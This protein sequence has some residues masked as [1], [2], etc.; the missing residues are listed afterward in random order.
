MALGIRGSNPIWSEVDLQGKLFDGSFY[1]YVLTNTIPYIPARVFHDPDMAIP[2]TQ[3]IQFN[4]NGTLPIDIFYPPNTVFRLEFRKNNGIDPP[5]QNDAL[6]YE[7]NDYVPGEGGSTPIDTVALA[8]SNQ[9]TN[10][11]FALVNFISPLILIG[12]TNPDPINIGPGWSLE[13]AG[14]GN[15]TVTQV[16]L[17]NLNPNPSNAPYAL[18]LTLSGW[19]DNSVKLKQRFQVNGMLWANK[20]VSSTVTAR[21]DGLPQNIQAI[22][23]DS[24]G[25]TL[26]NVMD[27]EPVNGNYTELTGHSDVLPASTNPD[28]PPVAWIEYQLLLPSNVDIYLT[29]IQLVVQEVEFEPPFEQDSI[30]RQ[31]DHT[32][33]DAFPIVPI[34]GVIDF[35][36][37][38]TPLNYLG[39]NGVEIS[40]FT[41]AMLFSALTNFETVTLT[42]GA[43]TFSV[44]TG[45]IYAAGTPIEGAGIQAGTVISS[46]SGNTVTISLPAT[47]SIS[48][49]LR[50]FTVGN[51]NGSTTFNLPDL[52]GYVTAGAYWN[53][54]AGNLNPTITTRGVGSAGGQTMHQLSIGEMPSHNH[55]GSTVVAASAGASGSLVLVESINP[56]PGTFP[57]SIASQGNDQ[58]HNTMQLTKLAHKIIRYK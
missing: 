5:S 39:C 55:P 20:I 12:A 42:N 36:G 24:N 1:L 28:V 56:A 27:L 46:I 29:S 34:G 7:V 2:W 43:N 10:P 23:V 32:Y 16:P 19:N 38:Q 54:V 3:P 37:F 52:R 49:T 18:R 33:H 11:Q 13:L 14:T 26:G 30:D 53:N 21:L 58:A 4:A 31:I 9:V 8:S 51:G 40:R 57:L 41:Y 47:A 17:N 25:T 48:S 44:I 50:F 15:V 6:I 22:L 35:F 45:D